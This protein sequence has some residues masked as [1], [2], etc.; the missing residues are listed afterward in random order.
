MIACHGASVEVPRVDHMYPALRVVQALARLA[1][2][3][4]EPGP[5]QRVPAE[6]EV[7]RSVR[8]PGA[9]AV[10]KSTSPTGWE[11]PRVAHRSAGA[12]APYV[13]SPRSSK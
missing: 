11:R 6:E 3:A 9:E 1:K 8:M 4:V 5:L 7:E 13:R 2:R 10:R 12:G